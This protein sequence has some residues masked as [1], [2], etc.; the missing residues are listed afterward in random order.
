MELPADNSSARTGPG[1]SAPNAFGAQYRAAKKARPCGRA[2]P[3]TGAS[4]LDGGL[5]ELLDALLHQTDDIVRR[6]AHEGAEILGLHDAGFQAAAP[7]LGRDIERLDRR[8]GGEEVAH[9]GEARVGVFLGNLEQLQAGFGSALARL[10]ELAVQLCRRGLRGLADL[11]EAFGR[12]AHADL[13]ELAD[14]LAGGLG[15]LGGMLDHVVEGGIGGGHWFGFLLRW[16][17][18]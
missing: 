3:A 6:L 12:L 4:A 14:A 15:G 13:G 5:G 11:L 9:R 7:V 10:E 1:R 2:F 8:L 18:W 16:G 17:Y